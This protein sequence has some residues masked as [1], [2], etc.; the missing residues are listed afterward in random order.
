MNDKTR[1]HMEETELNKKIDNVAQLEWE[2][3]RWKWVLK[4]KHGAK[5]FRK[6][7]K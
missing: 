4:Y 3:E 6:T 2:N 1:G 7:S 5:G